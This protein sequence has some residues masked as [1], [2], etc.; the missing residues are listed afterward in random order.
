MSEQ[1]Q[2]AQRLLAG[3]ENGSLSTQDAIFLAE[4]LDP[5]LIHALV[6]FLRAVY[7]ASDPAATSVLQ[8][9][10]QLMSGSPTVVRLHA[11]GALDPVSRWFESEYEYDAFRGRGPDLVAQIVD[12]L[13]S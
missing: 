12:K 3:L 5:V 7:P 1:T 13:E 10:V 11:E 4:E 2:R 6:S 8:R 9:V